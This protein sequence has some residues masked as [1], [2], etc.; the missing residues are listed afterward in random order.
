MKCSDKL[1]LVEHN[2]DFCVVGGGMAGLLAALSA[3]RNGLKTVL[4]QDRPVLGGN[5]SSEVRMWI[6]GAQGGN[7]DIHCDKRETGIIQEIEFENIY[8]NPYLN[9]SIWDSVLYGKAV[10]EKNLTLLLNCSCMDAECVDGVI[11]NVTAW[12]LT[13][14]TFHKVS[15]KFFADCS[16]DSILAPLVDA[17]Y[18]V[19][20]EGR[21]EFSESLAPIEADKHTMGMSC[22][23]QAKETNHPV[24]FT[25]PEWAYVYEKDEDFAFIP[26]DKG[27][28]SGF[29]EHDPRIDYCNYWWIELGGLKD[30]IHDTEETREELLKIVFGVW[31]HV[32]N[33]GDHGAENWELDWVGFLPGKRE[34]RRY[35]GDYV[36]NQ[37]DILADYDFHDVVAYGGWDMDDHDPTGMSNTTNFEKVALMT[38]TPKCYKIPYRSLY[39][40]NIENLFFAGRNISATHM[41]MSSTRVMATCAIMG[42]AIGTA[43]SIC[44]NKN[45]TPRGVYEK[46]IK[47]LQKMLMDANCFLPWLTREIPA[48]SLEAKLN[49]SDEDRALLFNGKERNI[50][51]EQNCVYI[52]EGSALSFS[53]SEEKE[54]KRLRMVLDSDFTRSFMNR[55]N[56]DRNSMGFA[57]KN[58]TKLT[59]APVTLPDNLAKEFTVYLVTDSGDEE[60]YSKKE[61]HEVL[62]R[63]PVGRKAKGLKIV[64]HKTWGGAPV[65][66]YACDIE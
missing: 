24:K 66:L 25:P 23:L 7:H 29:R 35:I 8:R 14:Y 5:A 18:T 9:F 65:G 10:D 15:A 12:Q 42:Q 38:P 59:L 55:E 34:S 43:A 45:L 2:V 3:A 64:F 26:D 39:S 54:I 48:L 57:M 46:E 58:N 62:F 13:T 36:L 51:G 27:N 50:N 52:P 33:R 6:C 1:R 41:A 17:L 21:N 32:K 11:K 37:N 20:R 31:D 28:V 40:K 4:I 53:F 63:I 47:T 56:I 19:G 30:S 22:I 44:V 60:I 61:C 16:G 49:I